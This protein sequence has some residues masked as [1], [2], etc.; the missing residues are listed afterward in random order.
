MIYFILIASLFLYSHDADST[1]D[2]IYINADQ[3]SANLDSSST[4]FAESLATCQSNIFGGR[5]C[6]EAKL[7]DVI[8]LYTAALTNHGSIAHH[9][10]VSITENRQGHFMVASSTNPGNLAIDPQGAELYSETVFLYFINPPPAPQTITENITLSTFTEPISSS[11]LSTA[12]QNCL[13]HKDAIASLDGICLW[14]SENDTISIFD[15][16]I[17]TIYTIPNSSNLEG[18][19]YLETSITAPSNPDVASDTTLYSGQYFTLNNSAVFRSTFE[20]PDSTGKQD[21]RTRYMGYRDFQTCNFY[22]YPRSTGTD[23]K[24]IPSNTIRSIRF[25]NCR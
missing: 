3:L 25:F 24:Y 11:N 12:R 14:F 17:D 1:S 10:I 20:P 6:V 15:N 7:G 21:L 9:K 2:S 13:N 4:S 22:S 18:W 16:G 5:V 19:Y 8:H 23:I